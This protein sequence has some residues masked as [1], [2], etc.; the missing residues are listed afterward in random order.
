MFIDVHAF[1]SCL[2]GDVSVHA[3]LLFVLQIADRLGF[4]FEVVV[5]S[6]CGFDRLHPPSD[7]RV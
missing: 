6:L 7:A 2:I 1:Q 4:L 5:N 3:V